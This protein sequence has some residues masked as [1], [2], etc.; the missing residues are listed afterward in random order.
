[1]VETSADLLVPAQR[2][3]DQGRPEAQVVPTLV[4]LLPNGTN[5]SDLVYG[6]ASAPTDRQNRRPQAASVWSM[7]AVEQQGGGRGR[8]WDYSPL[9]LKMAETVSEPDLKVDSDQETK[10]VGT[11][12]ARQTS[13][14]GNVSLFVCG[15]Q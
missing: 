15:L 13:D 6:H 14:T 2:S 9:P 11:S 12:E 1:M 3:V 4:L 8:V 7:G 10:T 5:G